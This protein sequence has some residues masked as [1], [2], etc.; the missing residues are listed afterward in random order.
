MNEKKKHNP[1]KIVFDKNTGIHTQNKKIH[2]YP[3][4]SIYSSGFKS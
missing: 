3:N 1:K 2:I 4:G